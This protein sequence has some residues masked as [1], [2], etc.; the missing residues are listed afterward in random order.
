ML[1]STGCCNGI[2]VGVPALF[3]VVREGSHSRREMGFQ[4]TFPVEMVREERSRND[5]LENSIV[6]V[7]EEKRK[8][9]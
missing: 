1:R 8:W 9:V 2:Y 3:W 4:L 6:Q 7:Q 5:H